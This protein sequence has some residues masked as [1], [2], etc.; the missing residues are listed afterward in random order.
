MHAGTQQDERLAPPLDPER[1]SPFLRPDELTL[2]TRLRLTLGLARQ[3]RF[4]DDVGLQQGLWGDALEQDLSFVLADISNTAAVER[5]ARVLA[6][7]PRMSEHQQWQTCLQQAQQLDAWCAQLELHT[8]ASPEPT[9]SPTQTTAPTAAIGPRLLQQLQAQLDGEL[10]RLLMQLHSTFGQG[11]DRALALLRARVDR[12]YPP[13]PVAAHGNALRQLWL[14]LCHAQRKLAVLAT[15]LLPASMQLGDHDPAMGALLSLVQ[16]VHMS[17]TP[18]DEFTN[19][20]TRYYYQD[21][22]GF[23][24][25]QAKADR[26]H[27]LL[28]RDPRFA[29]PVLLPLGAH[30]MGGKDARGQALHYCAEQELLL[31]TLKVQS[32][33]ALRLE[34]DPRISPEY[35]FAYAT[36]ARALTLQ[37]P[38]P[39]QAA[40]A[41]ARAW[42]LLGGPGSTD[43]GAARQGLAIASPLLHLS[44]G[45]RDITIDLQLSHPAGA[46]NLLK[47]ALDALARSTQANLAGDPPTDD[48]RARWLSA[49]KRLA[50]Y[51]GIPLPTDDEQAALR[52]GALL[53][54]LP[55]TNTP[56]SP[57]LP[58]AS[59]AWL[60][61]LLSLCLDAASPDALRPRLG[62]FF[63][64]WIS[65]QETLD[66]PDLA[67][68]RGHAQQ[69]LGPHQGAALQVDNPLSLVY[70]SKPLE[71]SLVFDRV[72]RGLWQA[73]LS[74]A[75]GWFAPGEVFVNRIEPG[76]RETTGT[77]RLRITLPASAP[78]IQACTTAVHGAQWPFLPVVQL[79]LNS[80]TRVF[81]CSLL[82]HIALDAVQLH[83]SARHVRQLLLYNQLGRLDASKPF[84]PFGPLPD[85]SAYLLFSNA[86]LASKPLCALSLQLQWAGLPGAGLANHYKVYAQDSASASGE[87][88]TLRRWDEA[89]FTVRPA[90]FYGA[91]WQDCSR[92]LPL[93]AAQGPQQTL[94]LEGDDLRRLHHPVGDGES[95][96][97]AA[98]DQRWNR[99]GFF[100]LQLDCPP[101]AFGHALYPHLLS[102]RLTRNSR[103]KRA[104]NKLPLPNE[105]YTPRLEQISVSYAAQE[106]IT[107]QKNHS[108]A[109]HGSQL[110]H[111]CPFGPQPLR[112]SGA[113]QRHCLLAAWPG[114]AQLYIG[115]G[116]GAPEGTLSLL[117]QLQADA[118][119][120]SLDRPR[121]HLQWAAWCGWQWRSLEPHR[122]LMD[123]TQ[124][125]LRTGIMRL[126]LP[127]GM[128]P[129]CPEVRTAEPRPLLW[130]RLSATGD[131]DLLAPVQ[132]IWAQAVSAQRWH[133]ATPQAPDDTLQILPA[134]S[135]QAVQPAIAGLANVLQPLASFALVQAEN[136]SRM[137]SRA[138]ERLRHRD[139]AITPWD[140]ERLVLQAFPEVQRAKCLPRG[141][142]AQ[143]YQQ[144]LLVVVPALLPGAEID[145]TQAY[146]LDAATLD[147]IAQFVLQRAVPTLRL[148]V[149]NAVY[150]RIQVRC[151]LKLKA[152]VPSGERLR[153]LNQALRDYLSPWR[154]GGIT[155]RFD[156]TLR[157]DEVEAYLR[158]Q[159]GVDSVGE[160]SLLHIVRNDRGLHRLNDSGR[161]T[162]RNHIA[163]SQPWSLAL[164]ERKHLLEL[165]DTE[166]SSSP[167]ATGLARLAV[168]GSFIIG[169]ARA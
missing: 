67:A 93:F 166:P 19:R 153:A 165:S 84:L 78:A 154:P 66:A 168:G 130:L 109:A 57:D 64:V 161:P 50:I 90:L 88:F 44:E 162:S 3:M 115:L 121:P 89:S 47:S 40:L 82:Q 42:P 138:A 143:G 163:P 98:L 167:R 102:D 15:E 106:R 51:E 60:R 91:Q 144:V 108:A 29:K 16:L 38:T 113:Q 27:V 77:L 58:P 157:A 107:P 114:G 101:T 53:D 73:Q 117:F 158:A 18:L 71:R 116:G 11:D 14:G 134:N 81:G 12:R 79:D 104:E 68:L 169:G 20:L 97:V 5:E 105:P 127:E 129:D 13:L 2:A 69:I 75:T 151:T 24:P 54:A 123:S 140:M 10:G 21:R 139:R 41:R 17:R 124:G 32:L 72:F 80:Q 156:W 22:L 103:I 99:Q 4:V 36:Q 49:F 120:E 23:A 55:A 147:A 76:D 126:D 125:L 145:A 31:S 74:T 112:H 61:F 39:E 110:L 100:R 142:P 45:E 136:E 141:T 26:V 37:P 46:D 164:P 149:R 159:P 65:S 119:A 43:F 152:G 148:L 1:A 132:G 135:I 87:A 131:L 25:A 137:R 48:V 94:T 86:E 62:R 56:P 160:V 52:L 146:R 155:A 111:L 34:S 92:S 70:G 63:A 33:L 133:Q 95:P 118:A 85:L 30:F 28:E 122:L 35:E 128:T 96:A 83:V 6:L 7:W 8:A 59:S 150:D 9:H